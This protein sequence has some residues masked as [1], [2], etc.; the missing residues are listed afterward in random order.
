MLKIKKGFLLRKLGKDYM[1]VAI[2]EASKSFNGMLRL[3]EAGAFLWDE[4]KKGISR[5][6]LIRK[7]LDRYDDLDA[8][9][10][11]KDLNEFLE[12]ISIAVEEV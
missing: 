6:E 1:A 12:S 10:A 11:E 3:N 5:E 8:E 9:T 7:M 2:G 4:L